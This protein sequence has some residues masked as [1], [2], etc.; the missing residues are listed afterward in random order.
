MM[1]LYFLRHGKAVEPG[2]PGAPDDA[3]RSLTPDGIE[4]MEAEAKAFEQLEIQPEVILTSPLLRTKQTA[5][6][7]ARRLEPKGGL[8][9]SELLAPGCEFEQLENLLG[10]H[11]A[12]DSVMLVGHEPDFSTLVGELIGRG[13]MA[14]VELKKGGLAFV[15]SPWPVRRGGGTLRWL[16][17]PKVLR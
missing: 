13:G 16:L 5:Q 11:A 8:V 12:A 15:E 17:P 1:K 4:E 14:L 2:S 7:V 6:I 3:G 9:E 10:K